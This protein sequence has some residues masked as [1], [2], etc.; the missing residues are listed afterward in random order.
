MNAR[1]SFH[2]LGISRFLCISASLAL[3]SGLVLGCSSATT[4]AVTGIANSSVDVPVLI[5]DAPSDQLVA[6]TLTLNSI[7]LTDSAGKTTSLLATPTTIEICHLNGVQA[8]LVTAKIPQDTYV[9]AAITYSNPQITYINSSGTP[10]VA[11]PTFANTSYTVTFPTPIT[12][13]SANT[14]LLFDLLAGQSVNISGTTVTVSPVFT[15]KPIGAATAMPPAGHNGTGMEQKGSVV[16]ASGTTLII[17]PGSGSNIS[18]TTN[19]STLY[20]GV[21]SLTALTAGQLVEVDFTLQ[22]GGV[23]LATRVEADPPPP[24]GQPQNKLVGPVTAVTAGSGFKMALM[25]GLGQS[26]NP[27]NAG[28][29]YTIT[30]N[31]STVFATA[32]QFVSLTGLP[33]TPTFTAA[34]LKAG[35]AV[36]VVAS[37]VSGTTATASNVYLVPQTLNGTVTAASTSGTYKV[38]TLT[39]ASGSAFATLSGATTVTAY[40]SAAPIPMNATAIGVGN[41]VRFNGLV[42]NNGGSFV[43]VAGCSPDGDPSH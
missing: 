19:A 22:S 28:T 32:P 42:L 2:K 34:N 6:F 8:A 20:Q 35:Q 33:F 18:F 14:S 39:L 4:P 31:S 12:I 38:F 15:V 13:S 23:L 29:I 40:T 36:G 25:E 30:T 10:V 1:T 9:A 41:T 17:Q 43:M 5:T 16:S 37:A 3:T 7:V 26:L 24:A 21:S 11:S 27:T